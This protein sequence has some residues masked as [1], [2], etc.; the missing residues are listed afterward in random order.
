MTHKQSEDILYD[1]FGHLAF[2]LVHCIDSEDFLLMSF[3]FLKS[4]TFM[5][6]FTNVYVPIYMYARF[7][8]AIEFFLL[9]FKT[10]SFHTNIKTSLSRNILNKFV[11]KRSVLSLN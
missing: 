7:A 8:M 5:F 9:C 3:S 6:Q 2:S 1:I 11:L 4:C 10:S